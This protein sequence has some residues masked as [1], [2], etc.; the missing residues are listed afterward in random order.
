CGVV[1]MVEAARQLAA[2]PRSRE[3]TQNP[4]LTRTHHLAVDLGAESGRAVLGRFEQ[5]RLSLTE[6]RRFPNTPIA[7]AG[8]LR[9]DV[10]SLWNETQHAV[11]GTR[12]GIASGGVDAGGGR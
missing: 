10:E 2:R 6:V 4:P 1:R 3:V 5:G 8:T 9:W 12:G 7:D 11:A